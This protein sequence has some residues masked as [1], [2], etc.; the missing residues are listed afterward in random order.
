L[1]VHDRAELLRFPK[2]PMIAS[3]DAAGIRAIVKI[4]AITFFLLITAAVWPQVQPQAEGLLGEI[5]AVI[6]ENNPVLVSQSELIQES[7]RLPEPGTT[8][9]VPGMTLGTGVALWNPDT[10][11]LAFIPS[12][13]LGMSF[14]MNDPARVLNVYRIRQEKEKA[15]QD[16]EGSK[17]A[18][19]SELFSKI[20]EIYRLK[21]QSRNLLALRKYLRDYAAAAQSQRGELAVGPDK[22][23]DLMERLTNID[24]ELE[25][26][27]SQL[28]TIM[29]ETA[30]HLG[31]NAWEELLRLLRQLDSPVS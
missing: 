12:I 16:W 3:T 28:E 9:A 5:V 27:N 15:R 29:M 21:S 14:S 10:N 4:S 25:T 11:S 18:A 13:T 19:L 7:E 31:G 30:M 23:W 1:G 22:L 20:R 6:M 26:A 8:F 24:I 17:N 2:F